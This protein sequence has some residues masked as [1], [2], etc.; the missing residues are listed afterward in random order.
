MATEYKLSFTGK[1]I[2]EKLKKIDNIKS[3][4]TYAKEGGYTGT[5]KDFVGEFAKGIVL[6][7]TLDEEVNKLSEELAVERSRINNFAN[8]E[9]GSTTGDAELIDMRIGANGKVYESAGTAVRAQ[10]QEITTIAEQLDQTLQPSYNIFDK[11]NADIKPFYIRASDMLVTQQAYSRVIVI[12]HSAFIGDTV[13]FNCFKSTSELGCDSIALYMCS[14]YPQV[15]GYALAT[16]NGHI[17]NSYGRGRPNITTDCEYLV[18]QFTWPSTTTAE[19]TDALMMQLIEKLVVVCGSD[20]GGYNDYP[21]DIKVGELLNELYDIRVGANGIKYNSSGEAVRGQV[22]SITKTIE[23]LDKDLK[24]TYNMF[25][26][27][28]AD[29]QPFYIRE[30]DTLI[31]QQSYS[32]AIVIKYSASAGDSLLF[33]CFK[34]TSELGCTNIA[35][36]MCSEYPQVGGYAMAIDKS[37][38]ENSY[39]RGKPN[40]I[41]NCEYLVLQFTWDTTYNNTTT[42]EL[43]AQL[44]ENLVIV[45][46]SNVGDYEDYPFNIKVGE[47]FDEIKNELSELHD[48]RIGYDDIKYSSAG[49]AVRKQINDLHR[50]CLIIEENIDTSGAGVESGTVPSMNYVGAKTVYLGDNVL[51]SATLG[52]GWTNSNNV[53]THAEGN[54]ADLTFETSVEEGAIYILEF[55]TSYTADEFIRVGI[56][57]RYRVLCYQGNS[58]ITVPLMASGGTTLYITPIKTNYN[59]SISNITLRKIQKEGTECVLELYSTTTK[60]H[61]Q[62]YGFWNTLIGENTAE[63][64]VGATRCIAIGYSTLNALQGGHRNI[65]IGTYAMSQLIGGEENV[66]IGADSMIYV[67]KANSCISIGMGSMAKGADLYENVVIGRYALTGTNDSTSQKNVAIGGSAGY[68][69]TGEGNTM[70]GYQAGYHIQTGQKN[71]IIGTDA[72]GSSSGNFNTIV[73]AL[74]NYNNGVNYSIAIGNNAKATKSNQAVFGSDDIAETLLKGNLIVRGSDGVYRQIV[75]NQD[76]TLGWVAI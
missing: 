48:I 21:C 76:G 39:G 59:G 74:A 47:K 37:H 13:L 52:D 30:S 9:E 7:S 6:G 71:T 42:D 24:P 36:F 2:N 35:L 68:K 27:Y 51:G 26:K 46:G 64:A 55:D 38:I 50:R 57:D 53:F 62:N 16:D 58:H 69:C 32:R 45:Y 33:N 70:L 22:K 73:G 17:E 8:L 12:K 75:F 15:G 56:G 60:N 43:M 14:E 25:D 63:N 72:H 3:A 5:E 28:N 54:M 66:S 41:A 34:S 11:Y 4:Y 19:A 44:I 29:I 49:N 31:T 1:Q 20:I 61:T 40:I 67:Q 65:G 10:F 23:Q 18:L